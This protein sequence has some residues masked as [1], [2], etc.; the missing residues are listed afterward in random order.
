MIALIAHLFPSPAGK[1]ALA[2]MLLSRLPQ[3]DRIAVGRE[4]LISTSDPALLA[5]LSEAA[6]DAE[7]TAIRLTQAVLEQECDWC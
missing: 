2:E 3:A 4:L 1:R 5:D 7:T 6:S